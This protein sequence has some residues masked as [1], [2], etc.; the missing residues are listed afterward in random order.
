MSR[1]S[2][3]CKHFA[4]KHPNSVVSDLWRDDFPEP[5]PKTSNAFAAGIV[6]KHTAVSYG[7]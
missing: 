5:A 1:V 3:G 6:D 7:K 2:F 4:L